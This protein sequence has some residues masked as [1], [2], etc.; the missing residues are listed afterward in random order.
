MIS[1]STTCFFWLISSELPNGFTRTGH[2]L[3]P[4]VVAAYP[5]IRSSN[6][7]HDLLEFLA[8]KFRCIMKTDCEMSS[9]E[10]I[11]TIHGWV[12]CVSLHH[13]ILAPLFKGIPRAEER[14]RAKLLCRDR[15][16][17][18]VVPAKCWKLWAI[19]TLQLTHPVGLSF[20]STIFRWQASTWKESFEYLKR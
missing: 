11:V 19:S 14:H 2:V 7:P 18:D 9:K 17:G 15:H 3:H 13:T 12:I 20:S 5:L 4:N 6:Q 10:G 16:D 8:G 1:T